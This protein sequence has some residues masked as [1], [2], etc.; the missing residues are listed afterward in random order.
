MED[1]DCGQSPAQVTRALMHG[2]W[3]ADALAV[4]EQLASPDFVWIGMTEEDTCLDLKQIEELYREHSSVYEGYE[5]VGER[6]DEIV[7]EGA[8]RVVSGAID[9]CDSYDHGDSRGLRQR[10]TAVYRWDADRPA[11]IHLHTSVAP[12]A[13]R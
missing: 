9:V 11:L 6:Y 7:C 4:L 3:S 12:A 13:A 10:V 2:L 1:T 5:I 8:L